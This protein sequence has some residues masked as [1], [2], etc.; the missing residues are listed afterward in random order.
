MQNPNRPC[1]NTLSVCKHRYFQITV[2]KCFTLSVGLCKFA[3]KLCDFVF[4]RLLKT[5]SKCR[6]AVFLLS[7]CAP[8]TAVVNTGDTG[9]SK[10]Y[11]VNKRKMTLLCENTCNSCYIVV[12]RKTQQVHSSVHTPLFRTKSVL[13]RMAYLKQ[14]HT[15]ETGIQS[16][17]TFV[18]CCRM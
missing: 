18:I 13:Q 1:N 11:C 2:A 12:I 17:V 15:V 16:F 7:L 3:N 9:H 8:L 5:W 4:L 10:E 14:V 6:I